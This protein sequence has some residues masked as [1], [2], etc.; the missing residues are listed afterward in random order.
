VQDLKEIIKVWV[1]R[2]YSFC[3]D[4]DVAISDFQIH[5]SVFADVTPL[6]PGMHVCKTP[7]PKE[8]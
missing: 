3:S 7:D 6:V 2:F 4:I 5:C 8:I 1:R